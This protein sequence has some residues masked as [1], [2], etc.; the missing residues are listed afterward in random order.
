METTNVLKAIALKAADVH[1]S[2]LLHHLRYNGMSFDIEVSKEVLGI[3]N[4]T[5]HQHQHQQQ[6]Q[7]NDDSH[8]KNNWFVCCRF[9]PKM[10]REFRDHMF[11]EDIYGPTEDDDDDIDEGMGVDGEAADE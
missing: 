7:Q 6:Q 10:L 4:H 8:N 9:C 5:H 2:V 3:Q 1:I 11:N